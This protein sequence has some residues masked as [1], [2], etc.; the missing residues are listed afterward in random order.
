MYEYVYTMSNA[1]Y[2]Y[3]SAILLRYT[4]LLFHV[5]ILKTGPLKLSRY[6]Y[7]IFMQKMLK[8]NMMSF[9]ADK[10]VATQRTC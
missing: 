6:M 4:G 10:H 9:D 1:L 8:V 2:M 5:F 3:M 7:C